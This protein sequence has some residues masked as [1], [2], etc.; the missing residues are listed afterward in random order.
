MAGIAQNGQERLIFIEVPLVRT[1]MKEKGKREKKNVRLQ[2]K[3]NIL[4]YIHMY[5]YTHP[6]IFTYTQY[7]L[8]KSDSAF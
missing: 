3:E 8:F 7:V 2:S 5:I 6:H 4:I 1:K